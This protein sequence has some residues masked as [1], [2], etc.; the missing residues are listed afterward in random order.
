[1]AHQV[2]RQ[3]DGNLAVFSD[4]VD[5]WVVSDASPAEL[6]EHYARRAADDARARWLDTAQAV[7]DGRAREKYYQFT[8]S[9]EEACQRAGRTPQE[10][11]A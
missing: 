9:Y 4:N 3:P 10:A 1:M 7:L 5:D 11:T 2:I 6:A 8:M